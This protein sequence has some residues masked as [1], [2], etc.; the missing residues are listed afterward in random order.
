MATASRVV[1]VIEDAANVLQFITASL[2]GEPIHLVTA[3]DGDRGLDLARELHPDLL[4]LDVALP[5]IDGFEVL[6][7]IRQDPAL[8]ETPVVIV[9]AHGDSTTA[10][11]ARDA[12]ANYFIAKPFRP[13]EL[14][15][16]VEQFLPGTGSKAS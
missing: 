5:G 14:R 13:T 7:E 6:Q 9:T 16:V 1:L 4:L 3:T 15:R 10:A 12:G 2:A 8:S 11:R